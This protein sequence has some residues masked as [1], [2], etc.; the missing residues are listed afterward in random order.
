VSAKEAPRDLPETAFTPMLRAL[1]RG[2]PTVLAAAFVDDEGECVDYCSTSVSAYE[3][4]VIGAQLLVVVK[5]IQAGLGRAGGVPILTHVAASQREFF[6]RRVSDDYSL[7]AL[8]K[9]GV[10]Q[11]ETIAM[12]ETTVAAFRAE[13]GIPRP[14]FEGAHRHVFVDV[15]ESPWGFAPSTLYER[16]DRIQIVDVLG[17]W[18]EGQGQSERLGFL[19][20]S[21]RGDELVL[22]CD[23]RTGRWERRP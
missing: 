17:R 6:V 18:T 11:G 9:R 14:R 1:I 13:A 16:G 10:H 22:F 3:A 12:I 19:T 8:T 23:P 5:L 20:R 15:R 7:V 21:E 4:K 2:A